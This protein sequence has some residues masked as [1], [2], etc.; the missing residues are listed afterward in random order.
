MIILGSTNG[1]NITFPTDDEKSAF[2]VTDAYTTKILGFVLLCVHMFL[3]VLAKC[4]IY[5]WSRILSF[6][7]REFEKRKR[8]LEEMRNRVGKS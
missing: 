5:Y 3:I 7:N 1:F 8:V 4:V 2:I 6:A